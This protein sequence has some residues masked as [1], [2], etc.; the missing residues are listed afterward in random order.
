MSTLLKRPVR[1]SRILATSPGHARAIE[2]PARAKIMAILYRRTMSADQITAALKKA[3]HAKA[4]TTVRHH[5]DVLR[6][7]GLIEVARIDEARGSITK[8]YGTS[9]K[10]LDFETPGDFD[11]KYSRLIS[12]TSAK[13][14]EIVRGIE[15]KAAG[16]RGKKS[17]EYSQYLLM[18]I[19]NRAVTRV[20]EAGDR[21]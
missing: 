2:D 3:G 8:F 15:P 1:V 16:G 14:E 18:E 11:A 19:V 7:A 20:L 6:G 9:T 10:L 4:L 13:L 17:P 5:I 12:S 21:R